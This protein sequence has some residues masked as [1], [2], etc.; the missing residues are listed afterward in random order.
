MKRR[1]L[2]STLF[3]ISA[4]VLLLSSVALAE[5]GP[6]FDL[7]QPTVPLSLDEAV[8]IALS[9]SRIISEA[10]SKYN[11]AMEEKK[12]A[13]TDFLPKL[14]ASYFYTRFSDQTFIMFD[15]AKIPLMSKDYHHWNLTATQ[16]IFSGYALY[17]KYQI[18]Q[19]NVD[20]KQVEKQLAI[21]DV[22]RSIKT[23]YFNILMAKKVLK[24]ANEVVEDL[25]A[26]V[27]DAE[28]FYSNGYIPYNDL[29][30]SRVALA[31]AVQNR[32]KAQSAVEMAVSNLNILLG[33]SIN[34]PTQINDV[35]NIS[36][37]PYSIEQ[38]T[39]AALTN[40]PELKALNIVLQTA[41]D[42]IRLAKRSYYPEVALVGN[43]ERMGNDMT[44]SNNNYGNDHN[45]TVTLQ[46]KW[47]IFEWGKTE[48]EVKKY[49][50]EKTA[51][52]EKFKGVEDGITLE[53]KNA[54]LSRDV[55]QK[56]IKTALASLDQAKENFRLTKLQYQHQLATTTNILDARTFLSQAITNYYGALYGYL[57]CEAELERVTGGSLT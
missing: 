32:E 54:F 42:S 2:R 12:S 7:N 11:A 1:L 37:R 52:Q 29:L 55:A 45:T 26:H 6:A 48:A 18:S 49:T 51:L 15:N 35:T 33:V 25:G 40:R 44:A 21:L 57:I 24:V 56:N 28:Q 3:T 19:L 47:S 31:D 30:Q 36:P 46:A 27:H 53:V 20:L 34:H 5:R 39:A 9:N 13:F 14:S 16:P 17:T 50:N 10:T 43:Y 41:D 22:T 4:S 38:L 8:H 23:F